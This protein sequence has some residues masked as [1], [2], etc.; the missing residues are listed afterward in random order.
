MSITYEESKIK[1]NTSWIVAPGQLVEIRRNCSEQLDEYGIIIECKSPHFGFGYD[2]DYWVLIDG[3]IV[4]IKNFMIY[5]M[6]QGDL[7]NEF[8]RKV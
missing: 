3:Q 5:P 4:L 7:T 6:K 1:Y 8:E 2:D